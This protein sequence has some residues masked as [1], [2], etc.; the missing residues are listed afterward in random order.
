MPKSLACA[1]SIAAASLGCSGNQQPPESPQAP[2]ESVEVASEVASRVEPTA[3]NTAHGEVQ[4]EAVGDNAVRVSV[5][6]EEAAPGLHGVHIHQFDD[7]SADDAS[8]AGGHFN[9][10]G[11]EHALPPQAARHL[12][13]LGN[14][15]IGA[16]GSGT[17]EVVVEDAS[18]DPD[19][20]YSFLGRALIV[21]ADEDTGE[22]DSG[23]A[24][25]RVAC[26]E[27][28]S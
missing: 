3:G 10:Q 14:I 22:G 16:D 11:F 17:L 23:E 5:S 18:L 12:G 6:I 24:G 21:H 9:P 19:S 4:L 28:S 25:A 15:E 8:S 13:D 1:I 7:C 20:P 27:I 26:A 2:T